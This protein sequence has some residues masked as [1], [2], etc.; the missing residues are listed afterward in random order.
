MAEL[1]DVV[2]IALI[3]FGEPSVN[4]NISDLSL[5]SSQSIKVIYPFLVNVFILYPL[6]MGSQKT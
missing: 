4:N 3:N 1:C 6:K 5:P 2:D